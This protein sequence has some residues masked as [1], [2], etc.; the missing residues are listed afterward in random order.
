MN[1]ILEWLLLVEFD[2]VNFVV[3]LIESLILEEDWEI[4]S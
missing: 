1:L 3:F 2:F 4:R